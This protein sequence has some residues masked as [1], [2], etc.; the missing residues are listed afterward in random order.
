MRT[1]AILPS[2]SLMQKNIW[3]FITPKSYYMLMWQWNKNILTTMQGT[4][5]SFHFERQCHT[6][7]IKSGTLM[8]HLSILWASSKVWPFLPRGHFCIFANLVKSCRLLLAWLS[9]IFPV[10]KHRNKLLF[11]RAILFNVYLKNGGSQLKSI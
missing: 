1:Q 3:R 7:C 4:C 5:N 11:F 2:Y 9:N 8:L 6:Q 10:T